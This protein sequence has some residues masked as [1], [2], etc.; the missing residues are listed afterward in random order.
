MKEADLFRQ[1]ARDAAQLS[2]ETIVEYEKR[3]LMGLACTWAIA[4]LTSEK[5]LAAIFITSPRTSHT[6][7]SLRRTSSRRTP[8]DTH[9]VS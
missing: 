5:M 1:Y 8:Q 6:T 3:A 4:A 9:G 7:V 2:L